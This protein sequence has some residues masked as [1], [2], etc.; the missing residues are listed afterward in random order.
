MLENVEASKFGDAQETEID[1]SM[2]PFVDPNDMQFGIVPQTNE[3][4]VDAALP[5]ASAP[6]APEDV[7]GTPAELR[8]RH[9]HL[10]GSQPASFAATPP[11][12]LSS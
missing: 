3:S 11:Q 4:D 8:A 7:T 1:V 5:K 9:G 10:R 6:P 12:S 2:S